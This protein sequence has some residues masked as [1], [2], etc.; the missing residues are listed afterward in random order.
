M[1]MFLYS[2]VALIVLVSTAEAQRWG[3]YRGGGG[4]FVGGVVGGVIGGVI[5]GAIAN[6]PR[7]YGYVREYDPVAE[8]ARR[9]RSYNPETGF[10]R[11]YDGYLRRCP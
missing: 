3:H 1:K 6:R 5:G 11:G 4:D 9:F 8:C 7:D 10:Y 2:L